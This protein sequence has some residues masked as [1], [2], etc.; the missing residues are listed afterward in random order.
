MDNSVNDQLTHRSSKERPFPIV[1]E[2]KTFAEMGEETL[3]FEPKNEPVIQ[4]KKE[5]QFQPKQTHT[6]DNVL[7]FL[8]RKEEE[9]SL[10]PKMWKLPLS[11]TQ[12]VF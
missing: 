11:T 6:T 8:Q 1:V 9:D 5:D 2:M 4:D 3:T 10:S 12:A 7:Q